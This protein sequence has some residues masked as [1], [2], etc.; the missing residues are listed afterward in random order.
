MVIR[1]P[2]P[3]HSLIFFPS[4]IAFLLMFLK[5]LHIH[6]NAHTPAQTDSKA[7]T[8]KDTVLPE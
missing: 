6:E 2:K 8:E 1:K 4:K 5:H 3:N 7:D